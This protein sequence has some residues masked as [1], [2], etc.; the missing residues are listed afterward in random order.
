MKTEDYDFLRRVV[1]ETNLERLELQI[2]DAVSYS[3]D[4]IESVRGKGLI[5]SDRKRE[6][7]LISTTREDY[8]Q[9]LYLQLRAIM[10]QEHLDEQGLAGIIDFDDASPEELREHYQ[11]Q[12]LDLLKQEEKAKTPSTS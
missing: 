8:L 2:F 9:G 5:R 12:M 4:A 3:I 7:L 11:Q 1:G 10:A 6:A